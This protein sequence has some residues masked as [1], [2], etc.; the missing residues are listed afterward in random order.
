[1]VLNGIPGAKVVPDLFFFLVRCLAV[2]KSVSHTYLIKVS[3]PPHEVDSCHYFQSLGKK[4]K[5]QR[6]EMGL[7]KFSARK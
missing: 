3:E 7:L 4:I 1:M 6:D 5:V 2:Y